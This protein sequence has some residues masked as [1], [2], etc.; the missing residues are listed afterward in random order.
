MPAAQAA[1]RFHMEGD[2]VSAWKLV[3]LGAV[4]DLLLAD[5][6]G[7]RAY[8]REVDDGHLS[9]FAGRE[10]EHPHGPKWHMSIS[11][12]TSDAKP[13]PGRYPTW[14]EITDARYRFVPD[15]VTMAMLLPPKAK[16]VNVHE[17]CFHLW[18]IEPEAGIPAWT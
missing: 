8:Q 5:C 17:T 9:V 18:E 3:P 7:I 14:D 2:Q 16:Y 12:R 10:P 1:G 13:Q 15:S 11:H 4:A 6:P